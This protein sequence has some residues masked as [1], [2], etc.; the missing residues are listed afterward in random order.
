VSGR[1]AARRAVVT[2]AAGGIGAALAQA[3][4]REGAAVACVDLDGSGAARTADEITRTGGT[5]L[6]LQ[7]DLRDFAAV[8]DVIDQVAGTLGPVGVLLANAGGSRGE[9]VPFLGLHPEI[10]DR[11]LD[12]NLRTAFNCGLVFG[13]HM[14]EHGGGAIVFTT[15]QLSIVTRP[16]LAHYAA[17]KG[18]VTQLMKGMAVDLASHGIRVNAVAPGPTETPGNRAWFSQPEVRAAN[19]AAIPLGRVARPEEIAG[20][21]MYL[22]SDEAAFTTGATIVVDGGYTLI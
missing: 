19:Q 9:V 3:A 20:A 21:A 7:A 6:G 8:E 16:G 2:G 15:S 4:A 5:A 13:R 22:A 14:A 10:W 11:M 18:G 17:A 1:L 12:R